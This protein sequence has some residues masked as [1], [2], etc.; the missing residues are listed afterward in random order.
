MCIV[1]VF[2]WEKKYVTIVFEGLHLKLQVGL[3]II[4]FP[5]A[6]H[7]QSITMFP[8]A[9]GSEHAFQNFLMH[10]V[11]FSHRHRLWQSTGGPAI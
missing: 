10:V 5:A 6:S 9:S 4:F 8:S 7:Y 11:L 1:R 3:L 2:F